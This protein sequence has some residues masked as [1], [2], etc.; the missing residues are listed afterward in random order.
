MRLNLLGT[1]KS[2]EASGE[3]PLPGKSNYFSGDDPTRWRVNVPMFS[4]AHYSSIYKGVDL[5]YYGNQA[6]L[7]Y[8][9]IVRP[10]ADAR[11]IQFALQDAKSVD[12]RPA[13]SLLACA[14]DAT[15]ELQKPVAYQII[16]G[17][18]HEVNAR[19]RSLDGHKYGIQ[20]GAYDR[21][22]ELVIDPVLAYSSYL[23]EAMTKASSE[24]PSMHST[25]SISRARP[26]R[27]TFLPEDPFSLTSAATTTLL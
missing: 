18:R 15:V 20:V 3:D 27:R 14:G 8:D 6:N 1:N 21:S 24:S 2:A 7:E 22:R 9:F 17:Q 4:R 10:G 12:L 26:R 16:D 5:V 23:G 13:G 25:T 11:I 19:F